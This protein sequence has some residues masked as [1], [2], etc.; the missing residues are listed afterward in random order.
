VVTIAAYGEEDLKAMNENNIHKEMHVDEEGMIKDDVPIFGGM[1]YLKANKAVNEDL[2]SRGLV[3]KDEELLHSVP[4]CWRCHT[5]L[6]YAPIDAWYVNIQN[7]KDLLIKTN[8]EVNWFPGHFKNGRFA[9]SMEA[10][11]DWNISRNRYWGSPVPVWEC[12]C[13][14]RFVPGSIKELEEKS[15]KK[16]TNLHKPEIDE[17]TVKCD[18]CGKTAKR[19]PEVLDSWIEA[20]SASFAERHFPFSGEDIKD[21]FPPDFIVEYT[22]Q[23]RA[24]FYVLHVISTAIYDSQAF[25][26]VLV[27]GVILGTDGRKMSKNYGNFPDPKMVMEQYGGDALRMYLMGS[28]VMHGEDVNFS[29]DGVP[30][31]TRGFLLIL[32]N[33]YKYFVDY[34]N[35]FNW[36]CEKYGEEAKGDNLKVLDRWIL[37]RL[38]ELV[39]ELNK[40]YEKYDTVTVTKS[41]RDFVVNDFS[42]WYI[43]RN[44]DRV[45]GENETERNIALSVMFGVLVVLSK[46]MAPLSP[47]IS[48]EMFK[49]LTGEESVHLQEFPK[50]DK[51]LLDKELISGMKLV[52]Q[53]VE[54]GHSK[55]KENSIKLRQPLAKITYLNLEKLPPDLEEIIKDELNVKSVGFK[56]GKELAIELDINISEDLKK[57]G[58]ARE[59]IRNIQKLRKEQGLTLNDA[60]NLTL[61]SWPEEFKDVILKST[62]SVSVTQGEEIKIELVS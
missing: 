11:P 25:K 18:S 15:G 19:V 22:G 9:K 43:R 3:Y 62:H 4:L 7:I 41:V 45:N 60:I 13:G 12:D 58:E 46:V 53:I 17:V 50:G 5:R 32:W 38:T 47:F 27:T 28:P 34:A 1:Y 51:S 55:R 37:A 39:L 21:F 48:E 49:T 61:P 56:N 54:M 33:C 52:R 31:V 29:N 36:S 35:I 44:R 2:S 26:N 14:E 8:E 42:T 10:A 16:I 57:E 24:W 6:Y 20:G 30:E 59:I 40:A 23:I